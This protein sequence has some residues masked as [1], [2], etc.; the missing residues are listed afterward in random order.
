LERFPAKIDVRLPSFCRGVS[1]E[2]AFNL[3]RAFG[4]T[5]YGSNFSVAPNVTY[6]E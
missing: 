6:P 1:I 5:T 2:I 4:K 3:A